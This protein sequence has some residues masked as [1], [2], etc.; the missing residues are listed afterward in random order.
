MKMLIS[1]I[2]LSAAALMAAPASAD[3]I[4]NYGI[5]IGSKHYPQYSYN[6]SNPG[7]YVR[8]ESGMTYGAYYNSERRMSFYGGYTYQVNEKIAVT[9]GLISGYSLGRDKTR[10]YPMIVPSLK[11]GKIGDTTLRLAIMPQASSKNYGATAIHL[12]A[13]W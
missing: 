1:A 10:I 6:N 5:H 9:V 4:A 3:E 12:M 8:M 13:E 11:L 2:I 7:I